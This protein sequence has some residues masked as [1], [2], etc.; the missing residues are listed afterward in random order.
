VG[1]AEVE[2]RDGVP[3]GVLRRGVALAP[4]RGWERG[5]RN[6][7]VEDPRV[8]WL[9][10]LGLHVMTYV[11]YG[12]LGPRLALAVS[13]DLSHWRR[14]G[15]V[16]FGYQADLDTDLGL[17]PNKD[18]VFFPEPVAGPGGEPCY[19]M[20]HR[21]MWDLSWIR[22]DET[23]NLPAGL[24][25]PR[26]GIWISYVPV[27]RVAEDL[28]AL[29]VLG[30][31]RLVALPVHPFE[32]LKIG[33]GPPPIRVLEGWLLLHHGVSGV[34]PH[35]FEDN[36]QHAAYAAGAMLLAPDDPSRV[37]ARTAD[38]LLDPRTPDERTG[39]VANVVFPTAIEE[40]GGIRYVFYG[41]ADSKIG[42]ARLDHR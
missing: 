7:G 5:A 37:L 35:G 8:T 40:V 15:P 27:A 17:F 30:G 33:A 22:P 21:P 2:L 1:L 29:Q 34:L 20:L 31:H 11:A 28:T 9:P 4:D 10:S 19:A 16:L 3:V 23:V 42:V 12:P 38:P 36:G 14:L 26:P 25:D 39:T 24:T 18:A 32:Q 41:M 6:A 13:P